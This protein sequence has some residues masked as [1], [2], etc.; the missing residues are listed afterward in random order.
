MSKKEKSNSGAKYLT[1]QEI[2]DAQ[3]IVI[4]EVEVPEWGGVVRLRSM[5]GEEAVDFAA[6]AKANSSGVARI[7]SICAVDEDGNR[8]FKDEDIEVLKRKSMRALMRLQRVALK[9]N[10]LSEEE[11]AKVKVG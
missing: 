4:E 10:G 6:K 9:I 2:Y 11:V 3:D 1:L 5:T 8:L 7:V